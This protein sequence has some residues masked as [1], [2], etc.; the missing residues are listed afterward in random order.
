MAD[1]LFNY[2]FK[3]SYKKV[4]SEEK[5]NIK[6]DEKLKLLNDKTKDFKKK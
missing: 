1:K 4:N 5:N 2:I 6:I 3:K